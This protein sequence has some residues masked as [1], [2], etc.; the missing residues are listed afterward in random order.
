MPRQVDRGS[1]P[2]RQRDLSP[3]ERTSNRDGRRYTYRTRSSK[4]IMGV[5]R[6]C[7]NA[8]SRFF[9]RF[10]KASS[11]AEHV[12]MTGRTFMPIPTK[13]ELAAA[14]YN[15]NREADFERFETYFLKLERAL[16]A[17]GEDVSDLASGYLE[18]IKMRLSAASGE[19]KAHFASLGQ[20]A[21]R[22]FER[23]GILSTED[24]ERVD[25]PV[26]YDLGFVNAMIEGLNRNSPKGAYVKAHDALVALHHSNPAANGYE[27]AALDLMTKLMD[28][29]YIEQGAQQERTF[30][31]QAIDMFHDYQAKDILKS[32]SQGFLEFFNAQKVERV[33]S[34]TDS[35]VETTPPTSPQAPKMNRALLQKVD[36]QLGKVRLIEAEQQARLNEV[37]EQKLEYVNALGGLDQSAE[38][39]SQFPRKTPREIFAGFNQA[40]IQKSELL[41]SFLD[42]EEVPS[43]KGLQ[44]RLTLCLGDLMGADLSLVVADQGRGFDPLEFYALKL[45]SAPQERSEEVHL[46]PSHDYPVFQAARK[47]KIKKSK[48]KGRA[49]LRTPVQQA[50]QEGAESRKKL[51]AENSQV[52]VADFEA[53]LAAFEQAVAAYD[54]FVGE[55]DGKVKTDPKKKGFRLKRKK[56]AAA[57]FEAKTALLG[58]ASTSVIRELQNYYRIEGAMRG[59]SRKMDLLRAL[60]EMTQESE[61]L[62]KEQVLLG[63]G[64]VFLNASKKLIAQGEIESPVRLADHPEIKKELTRFGQKIRT[65]FSSREACADQLKGFYIEHLGNPHLS[66][67][68][69]FVPE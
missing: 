43:L 55:L 60:D 50:L 21:A 42:E 48:K 40:L 35:A 26:D 47:V 41:K 3:A 16:D 67:W 53:K 19:E 1:P 12:E 20:S 63:A 46:E 24:I 30:V 61:V 68:L 15:L 36:E 31:E 39:C 65:L 69:Q 49:D 17:T 9:T 51:L 52:K 23:K 29:K 5:V 59:T 2:D 22:Y 6:S 64:A 58:E 32:N 13:R 11:R 57:P 33:G 56:T 25:L 44:D 8:L 66:N 54:R 62:S 37:E 28:S 45:E 27:S 10:R 14:A 7:L 4:G 18:K 34:P 38:A